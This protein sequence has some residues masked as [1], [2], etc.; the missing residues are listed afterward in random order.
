[1]IKLENIKKQ[2]EEKHIVC[3]NE[4]Y[5]KMDGVYT[6]F[7]INL[8]YKNDV[9]QQIEQQVG[10]EAM[11]DT[12]IA[13]A[14]KEVFNSNH[15]II[16][17]KGITWDHSPEKPLQ[18]NVNH[19]SLGMIGGE[20]S[21]VGITKFVVPVKVDTETAEGKMTK[22]DAFAVGWT[23]GSSELCKAFELAVKEKRIQEV[24]MEGVAI[25]VEALTEE[26]ENEDGEMEET[27]IG[28]DITKSVINK[29]S[30]VTSEGAVRGADI[31]QATIDKKKGSELENS[32]NST[33]K[34]KEELKSTNDK[35]PEPEKK[36]EMK[37]EKE[38][39]PEKNLVADAEEVKNNQK[40]VVIDNEDIEIKT[41]IEKLENITKSLDAI[42]ERQDEINSQL[43]IILKTG[44]PDI[45]LKK[46]PKDKQKDI[47][48]ARKQV[49]DRIIKTI[50]KK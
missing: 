39:K 50:R 46:E 25:E 13:I 20:P 48:E 5:I 14:I 16:R 42:E 26:K 45:S 22:V 19:D 32:K 40:D 49:I 27:V 2:L 29:L 35:R 17:M 33:D 7:D 6:A 38:L 12:T 8:E 11:L 3:K 23:W 44:S 31:I 30:L 1:M 34:H 37:K 28:L 9:L 21:I 18:I 15:W 10:R 41:I 43:A 4:K 24:S 47:V 36:E